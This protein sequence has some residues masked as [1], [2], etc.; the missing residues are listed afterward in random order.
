MTPHGHFGATWEQVDN[1]HLQSPYSSEEVPG[2][3]PLPGH[4]SLNPGGKVSPIL[5]NG[6][7]VCDSE[8]DNCAS[9]KG[10]LIPDPVLD[11]E[12][13]PLNPAITNVV[14]QVEIPE[15]VQEVNA[16][17]R[18][19]LAERESV[20]FYYQMIGTQNSNYEDGNPNLGPGVRGAQV[21]STNNLINTTLE[22]YTQ[23]GWSC[24]LCHQNAFP[25][26]VTLPLPPFSKAYEP[27]RTISFL[28]QNARG[29][30]D[31]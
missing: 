16:E 10:G 13:L 18:A 6:Y 22:S 11:G 9:G 28:L 26:G 12:F 1:T 25:L 29:N 7:E 19:L 23:K 4:A 21:S 15:E 2:A 3:A 5:P 8:G 20:W 14:R 31:K 24:A 27:L 17:W 30:R